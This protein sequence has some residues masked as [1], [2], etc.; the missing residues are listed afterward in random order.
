MPLTRLVMRIRCLCSVALLATP[1]AL[2]A[3]KK[4][5]TQADWDK[6][7]S[8]QGAAI[9]N[10]GKWAMYSLVPLVGDGDLIIHST[11]GSQEYR[12]PR[13]Y[14]GRPNNVPGGLRPGRGGGEDAPAAPTVAAGE[15]TPD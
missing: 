14:L 12:V 13:G 4:T 8:I 10:D 9:S 15:F 3:Q 11:S 7:K 1:L 6:W 5:L 2:H